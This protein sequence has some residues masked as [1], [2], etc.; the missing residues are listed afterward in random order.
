MASAR[1][2]VGIISE[3]LS[4]FW[5]HRYV[6]ASLF[7]QF[8]TVWPLCSI[9]D[10]QRSTKTCSLCLIRPPSRRYLWI[11]HCV[12]LPCCDAHLQLQ[13]G[14]GGKKNKNWRN[15]GRRI[16]MWGASLDKAED[17]IEC[18][19][20]HG[21]ESL[22]YPKVTSKWA[23]SDPHLHFYMFFLHIYLFIHLMVELSL[24]SWETSPAI[25]ETWSQV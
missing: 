13:T 22:L 5:C 4:W 8:E 15:K 25:I 19:L 10:D 2:F 24:F 7:W 20:S 21:D 17:N 12:F 14:E 23:R 1:S 11:S 6:L 3:Y 18:I 9:C 16:C